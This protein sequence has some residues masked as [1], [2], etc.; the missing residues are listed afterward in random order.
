MA[1]S[2]E[3]LERISLALD[4]LPPKLRSVVV[5]K[6]VYDLSHEAIADELGI[7][8][9]GGEG[10]AAPGPPQAARRALRRRSRGSCG[11]KRSPRC[12]PGW[13]TA[14]RRRSRGRAPRRDV[15]ALPGR[16]RP[17]PATPPHARV[18]AHPLRRADAGTARR[19]ARRAHRRRRRRRAPHAALGP[20][21]RVRRGDRR[22]GRRRRS[23][24]RPPD[25]PVPQAARCVWPADQPSDRDRPHS[26]RSVRRSALSCSARTAPKGSSS[27]G[28]AP[29]SK[30]GGWG[31]DSLLPCS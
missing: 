28:R 24:R 8:V 2:A 31:F 22:H 4:E 5:L 12:C 27:I 9:A 6:D 25:R 20:P 26:R 18:V 30:T 19:D 13:S 23:H 14:T 11:V 3:A 17:L 15:P 16:A 29:V 10:S 7:T 1:E 21:A